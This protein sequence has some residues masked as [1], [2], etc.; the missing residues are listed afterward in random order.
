ME[1]FGHH[2]KEH[3]YYFDKRLVRSS[4]RNYERENEKK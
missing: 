4:F 1:T 2:K 3:I